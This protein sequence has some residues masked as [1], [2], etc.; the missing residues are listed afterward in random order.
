MLLSQYKSY[1]AQSPHLELGLLHN[2]FYGNHFFID[3]TGKVTGIIDF[4]NATIGDI[5]L[6]FRFLYTHDTNLWSD[7]I[8]EY[9]RLSNKSIDK[10]FVLLN[11]KIFVI[12]H[13]INS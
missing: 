6:D 3:T 10:D 12:K 2:D 8:D 5:Q 13:S 9:C 11:M 1:Y 4:S 7:V